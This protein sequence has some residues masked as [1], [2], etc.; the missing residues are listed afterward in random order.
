M[1]PNITSC[2]QYQF[3][4]TK[5]MMLDRGGVLADAKEAITFACQAM[6]AVVSRSIPVLSRVETRQEYILGKVS[7]GKNYRHVMT[8]GMTFGGGRAHLHP[9][10]EMIDLVDGETLSYNW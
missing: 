3:P 10:K 9:G 7:P 4:R 1:N 8:R 6:E 5:I 2:L